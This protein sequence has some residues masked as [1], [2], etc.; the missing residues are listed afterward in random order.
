MIAGAAIQALNYIP[1]TFIFLIILKQLGINNYTITEVNTV[2][3]VQKRL[4]SKT[5]VIHN[6]QAYGFIY[7]YSFVANI[8][9]DSW[10][11]FNVSIYCSKDTYESLTKEITSE[12]T[13][14]SYETKE[15][16]KEKITIY[17]RCG[18]YK[19][20]YYQKRNIHVHSIISRSTQDVIIS[21]ILYNYSKKSH[22]VALLHGPPNTGKTTIGMLIAKEL[23]GTYCNS[24]QP[25]LPNCNL[26]HLYSTVEPSEDNPL[27]IAI[28]EI[29]IALINIHN[30]SIKHN[31]KMPISM[32]DKCGWNKFFDEIQRGMYPYLIVLLTTNKSPD[33]I[34]SLDT[35]YI[36]MGRVDLIQE[37]L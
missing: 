35:S 33:F 4:S 21:N 23:N 13:N 20:I 14:S 8:Y 19:D 28:D 24:L 34:N 10:A 25:W 22:T 2:K 26:S 1:W 18:S 6:E 31:E 5:S 15:V 3:R 36:R 29:D 27:V 16:P 32:M 17:D 11:D 9:K 37:L 12:N 30:G 7:D